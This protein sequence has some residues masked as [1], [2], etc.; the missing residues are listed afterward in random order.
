MKKF[1]AKGIRAKTLLGFC[2]F[3]VIILA[4]LW[5]LQTVF[6]ES[7][8]TRMKR[9]QIEKVCAEVV[10]DYGKEDYDG[11]VKDAAFQN[12]MTILIFRVVG[13]YIIV[14]HSGGN[15]FQFQPNPQLTQ[16]LSAFIGLVRQNSPVSYINERAGHEALTYGSVALIGDSYVY[17]YMNSSLTPVKSTT[18]VLTNQLVIITFICLALAVL[19]SFIIS[20][21]I[22][23]PLMDLTDGAKRLAAGDL[24]VKFRGKGYTEADE[25]SEALNYATDELK[26][27]DHLRKDLISNVSHELKTPLTMITAYAELIRDISGNDAEKRNAHVD[28]IL[29]ESERL[30]DMVNDI[31]DLSKLQAGVIVY[32]KKPVNLSSMVRGVLTSFEGA[33]GREGFVF[34]KEIDENIIICADEG[35][36]KQV[37]YNLVGNA[38][39]YTEENKKIN[40]R[41]KK[42][43]NTARLDVVDHGTG[44]EEE[45]QKYVFD[46]YFRAEKTKR[47]KVGSGI[48]LSIVKSILD[49]HAFDY[50]VRSKMNEGSDFYV[51][52]Q[53][54]DQAEDV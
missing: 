5:L 39:N 36:I 3:T 23:R 9:S 46:R 25:L 50:G 17:F 42:H 38:I 47:A 51:I 16:S 27:T 32:D 33:Y 41:L 14:E 49:A 6:L 26:K 20:K 45:E 15:D 35:R 19:L 37:I 21:S 18:N 22:S 54:D 40:V 31:L 29:K 24:D 52:F 28:V 34:D 2:L 10:S 44:I 48:G 30:K 43:G 4:F 11:V 1:N 8:Y 53:I 7:F 12:E 13:N